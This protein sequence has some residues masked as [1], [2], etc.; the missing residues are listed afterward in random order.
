ML[1]T[2]PPSLRLVN[3]CC[4]WKQNSPAIIRAT[5]ARSMLTWQ[6]TGRIEEH[7]CRGID[8]DLVVLLG[9]DDGAVGL[10]VEVLLTA[11]AGG[12]L[13]HMVTLPTGK[14]GL[15][16]AIVQPVSP[17][18]HS[19]L[20]AQCRLCKPLIDSQDKSGTVLAAASCT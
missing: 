8:A 18:L 2:G 13:H 6:A 17:A 4:S 1:A 10:Q 14:A 11:D 3:C 5:H 12:A 19:K 20:V 15:H 9:N 16:I 7:L